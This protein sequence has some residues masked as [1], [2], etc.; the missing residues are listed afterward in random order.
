MVG[1]TG[2]KFTLYVVGSLFC[3]NIFRQSVSLIPKLHNNLGV[4]WAMPRS[5][6]SRCCARAGSAVVDDDLFPELISPIGGPSGAYDYVV[7]PVFGP[8]LKGR[9][10]AGRAR[11]IGSRSSFNAVSACHSKHRC[12]VQTAQSR[13]CVT[14]LVRTVK[15]YDW[16]I[17]AQF[18]QGSEPMSVFRPG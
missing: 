15:R 14:G 9:A 5:K 1:C 17:P 7:A 18:C 12:R 11:G 10:A 4:C 8:I 16:A 3:I 2:A 13:P 6:A